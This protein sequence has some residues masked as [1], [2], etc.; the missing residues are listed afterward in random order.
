MQLFLRRIHAF[1]LKRF[2]ATV[3]SACLL[4]SPCIAAQPLTPEE[5]LLHEKLLPSQTQAL[6]IYRLRKDVDPMGFCHNACM[7]AIN[8][9]MAGHKDGAVALFNEALAAYQTVPAETTE[10]AEDNDLW[11]FVDIYYRGTTAS[12][13]QLPLF[14]AVVDATEANS[15]KRAL[16]VRSNVLGQLT[17]FTNQ[18]CNSE[19]FSPQLQS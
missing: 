6:E 4:V 16:V 11:W 7:L 3:A 12:A 17:Y 10:C 9:S 18:N 2:F 1:G 14:Y 19:A 15:A 8:M 13:E 5:R